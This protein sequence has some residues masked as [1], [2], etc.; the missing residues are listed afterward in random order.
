[1]S[2][3]FGIV[4]SGREGSSGESAAALPLRMVL[5][6][7]GIVAMSAIGCAPA[8]DGP[9][10][11]DDNLAASTQ[12]TQNAI[13]KEAV[14]ADF[15]ARGESADQSE[16]LDV[17]ADGAVVVGWVDADATTQAASWA[18]DAATTGLGDLE[19]ESVYSV[20]FSVSADGSAVVGESDSA[21][22]IEAFLWTAEGGMVGLGNLTDD[23]RESVAW[24]IS[25]DGGV[26][27]G[28]AYSD[29][30]RE[31]FRW[32]PEDG[33]VGLGSLTGGGFRDSQAFGVSADGSA[34]VGSSSSE[35]G[36]QAFR[37]TVEQGMVGLGS[38]P[39]KRGSKAR[40]VSA[41]SGTVVGDAG[42]YWSREAFRWTAEEGIV[43][44]GYLPG[45]AFLSTSIAQDV[46]ADGSV[47]VG[48]ASVDF[49]PHAFIW[50]AE[51]GMRDLQEVLIGEF[52]LDL[53]GWQ[54]SEARGVSDDGKTIVGWGIDPDGKM[55]AWRVR[56]GGDS[57]VTEVEID[58][59]PGSDD[60][61]IN[62]GSRGTVPVAILSTP[63]FDATNVDAITIS[64]AG[65]GV[66]IKKKGTAQA[67]SEDVNDD[68]LLDLVVHVVT[69]DLE[70]S[71]E[72]TEAVLTAQD[73]DGNALRGADAVR[74]VP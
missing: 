22:G 43:A 12:A 28:H 6:I 73:F 68:G 71:P 33:M 17:S 7:V 19:G 59:K 13:H 46:A 62:L 61:P 21:S 26:A 74:L 52:G 66:K 50:D 45:A 64:L 18:A 16:A 11:A 34:I 30:G 10:V 55:R 40:A 57:A 32:T 36:V 14:G 49:A 42:G 38:L 44:L 53:T 48:A 24:G 3:R 23:G 39:T 29:S 27:V 41:D 31:A 60:N 37:W 1:M 2:Y 54:L 72:D 65:A 35:S 69:G 4:K 63:E 47:I 5:P 51:N 20:A 25:A 8:L 15:E 70:L 56:L 58:I 9:I 67:A